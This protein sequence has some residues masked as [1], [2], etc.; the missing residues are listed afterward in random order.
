ME[1]HIKNLVFIHSLNNFTGS[2]NVLSVIIQGFIA[3]GYKARLITSRGEGFLTGIEKLSYRYT[4]YQ[5]KNKAFITLLLLLFSQLQLFFHILFSERKD[6]I[7]YINTIVPVGAVLAC[8]L[9]R[10]KFIYHVHENMQQKKPIYILFR[11]IYKRYNQKT[12]FVSDYLKETA[13]NCKE[14]ITVYNGLNRKF[15]IEAGKFLIHP[16]LKKKQILMVTSLRKFKGIYDFVQL[17]GLLPQYNFELVL[18]ATKEETDSF[19]KEVNCT[20]NLKVYSKQENMHPFYQRARLLL[21]LSH[22][23]EW[24]ETFGLTILEAM[25]YGIPAIVPD[26]GGPKE[27]IEDGKNGYT[28][29][30]HKT[31]FIALK[32]TELMEEKEKYQTFSRNTL[33]RSKAFSEEK[34]LAEIEKYINS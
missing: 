20:E 29:N 5:W 2:P 23:E 11:S 14:G 33:E 19:I 12:I 21:Q 3:K 1:S 4:C 16:P 17:A 10:K 27:L 6:T 30:P 24:I 15:E 18:S 32:I 8:V 31:E 34:M 22:P 9:T 28:T 13:L 7:Y 25:V 26:V